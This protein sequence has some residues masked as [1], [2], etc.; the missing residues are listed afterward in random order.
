MQLAVSNNSIYVLPYGIY[1]NTYKDVWENFLS[2][3]KL[4]KEYMESRS[5]SHVGIDY[6]D[7]INEKLSIGVIKRDDISKVLESSLTFG[8]HKN[9]QIY[10]L[11]IKNN[12][13]KDEFISD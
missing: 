13:F 6:I 12:Y 9:I 4:L 3:K 1:K 11:N 5:K 10:D 2:K 7:F 8:K